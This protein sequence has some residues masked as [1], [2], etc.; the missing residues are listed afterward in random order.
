MHFLD[1]EFPAMF[2]ALLKSAEAAG[3]G[4][5]GGGKGCHPEAVVDAE[6]VRI[7][8]EARDRSWGSSGY[9]YES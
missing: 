8:S 7:A 9:G 1:Y 2:P 4:A 6:V 5:G 3:T